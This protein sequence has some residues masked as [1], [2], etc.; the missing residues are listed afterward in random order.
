[1]GEIQTKKD[2]NRFSEGRIEVAVRACSLT[3]SPPHG[4]ILSAN[5][6]RVSKGGKEI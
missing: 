6:A 2:Q 5:F 3:G 1:M 4:R